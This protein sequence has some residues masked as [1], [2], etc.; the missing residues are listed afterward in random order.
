MRPSSESAIQRAIVAYLRRVLPDAIVHHS[1]NEGVRGGRA[2]WLDGA[3]AK[4][5]GQVAGFPDIIVLPFASIG[6]LFLE[7]KS[8]TGRTSAAQAAM[9]DRLAA[10]GYRV[11]VVRSIDDVRERLAAWGIWTLDRGAA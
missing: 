3:L 11:A 7:V 1:P 4:S 2:G 9:L 10:L 6:P 8:P 5:A